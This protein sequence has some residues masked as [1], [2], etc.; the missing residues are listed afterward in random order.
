MVEVLFDRKVLV[1]TSTEIVAKKVWHRGPEF[2]ARDIFD[3]AMVAEKEPAALQSIRPVLR[4]RRDEV[5]QRITKHDAVLRETFE[6]LEVIDYRRS[7]NECV[8][9]VK[10]ALS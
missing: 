4:S 7:F 6:A 10:E 9:I 3:L 2:T 8:E 5:L 1:E